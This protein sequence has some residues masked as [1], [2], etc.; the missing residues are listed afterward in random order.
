MQMTFVAFVD[1]YMQLKS[2]CRQ[3]SQ[4]GKPDFI[5]VR[6]VSLL[7]SFIEMYVYRNNSFSKRKSCLKGN[8]VL[9][10]HVW[11]AQVNM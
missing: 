4:L 5:H 7:S 9:D 11:N 1:I 10:E 2:A 8:I 3:F 6:K